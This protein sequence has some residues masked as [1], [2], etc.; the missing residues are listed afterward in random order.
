MVALRASALI[1]FVLKMCAS[2]RTP[3]LL[4]WDTGLLGERELRP[5]A[6]DPE[7]E[8]V[9]LWAHAFGALAPWISPTW[10]MGWAGEQ[11]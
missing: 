4:S 7:R 9:T 5:G 3:A 1:T 11:R 8:A 6:P 2:P 10:R